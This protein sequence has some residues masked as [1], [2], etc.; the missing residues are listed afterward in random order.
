MKKKKWTD[1]KFF[2]VHVDVYDT[3]LVFFVDKKEEEI[4]KNLKKISAENYVNFKESQLEDW[5]NSITTYGRM[6]DFAGGFV[7][8]LKIPKGMGFREFVSIM[9]H[10][11]VHVTHYLLRNRRIPL[12]EETEEAHTYLTEFITRQALNKLY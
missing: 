10:E 9:V 12:T 8:V 2:I 7:V 1:S 5:D 4:K 11:I 6:L 3:D